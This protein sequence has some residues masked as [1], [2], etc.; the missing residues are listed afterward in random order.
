MLALLVNLYVVL[1]TSRS[2]EVVGED[3]RIESVVNGDVSVVRGN[4]D[5]LGRVRGD[6]DVVSGNVHL[7]PESVVEGD[8]SVVGG[9]LILDS[10]AVIEGDVALVAGSLENNGGVIKGEVEKVSGTVL[11]MLVKGILDN[12]LKVVEEES[13][14]S[15]RPPHRR[16]YY[17]PFYMPGALWDLLGIFI[18][19]AILAIFF[20]ILKRF[21]LR[22]VDMIEVDLPRVVLFGIMSYILIVPILL[23]LVVS[24]VGILLV[25]LYLVGI[26]MAFFIA[27]DAGMVYVGRLVRR[28]LERDWGEWMDFMVGFAIAF[29]LKLIAI[30][31][32]LVPVDICCFKTAFALLYGIYLLA[33]S[34][35][36]FGA[37]FKWIF[38][39]D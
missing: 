23:L 7:F 32:S 24:I 6:V 1:D 19:F 25:P 13:D 5:I 27:L 38:R 29:A 3:V 22:M 8:V 11:N 39:I 36:G 28:N 30:L 9:D 31:V 34:I 14:T 26:V 37:I 18:L 16:Y 12:T 2:I 33:L 17:S 4:L 35:L 20:L 15:G 10:G 21:I